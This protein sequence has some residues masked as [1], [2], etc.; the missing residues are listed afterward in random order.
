MHFFFCGVFF[1]DIKHFSLNHHCPNTL[2]FRQTNLLAVLKILLREH[3]LRF[4]SFLY[5]FTTH[6]LCLLRQCCF[7]FLNF[8]YMAPEKNLGKADFFPLWGNILLST[9]CNG[10]CITKFPLWLER[11]TA[12]LG[13]VWCSLLVLPTHFRWFFPGFE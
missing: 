6:Q 10:P 1:Y 13:S 11:M 2:Y 8:C 4:K 7:V 3:R 12:L 5:V 9:I